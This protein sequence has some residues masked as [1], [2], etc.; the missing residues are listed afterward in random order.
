MLAF[1]WAFRQS[2]GWRGLSTYTWLTAALAVPI[3]ALKGVAFY[4]FLAAVLLWTTQ[5]AWS[6]K[7]MAELSPSKLGS[8]PQ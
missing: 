3:F 7:K 8:P 1:G 2:S 4:V 6:L 5:V